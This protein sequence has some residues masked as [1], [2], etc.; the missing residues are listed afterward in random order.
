MK[1]VLLL[2][3]DTRAL[4]GLVRFFH[5][6]KVEVTVGDCG[7]RSIVTATRLAR[8]AYIPTEMAD[9][10]SYLPD[11]LERACREYA[12]DTILP[13]TDQAYWRLANTQLSGGIAELVIGYDNETYRALSDKGVVHRIAVQHFDAP[14]LVETIEPDTRYVIKDRA[15]FG[16][17]R[18]GTRGGVNLLFGCE[19]NGETAHKLVFEYLPGGCGAGIG[20]VAKDGRVLAMSA[21]RR[22]LEKKF[23]G[24][25]VREHIDIPPGMWERVERFT[26]AAGLSGLNMIEFKIIDGR[27]HFIELNPRPWG[28][29]PLYLSQPDFAHSLAELFELEPGPLRRRDRIQVNLVKTV[30]N[31]P[32]ALL[33]LLPK[34]P[35]LAFD[36]IGPEENLPLRLAGQKLCG[37]L[38]FRCHQLTSLFGVRGA[39][40]GRGAPVF[41]CFGNINRSALAEAI[42]LS[43]GRSATSCGTIERFG[44]V[45]SEMLSAYLDDCGME[46]SGRSRPFDPEAENLVIFDRKIYED[47]VFRLGVDR[48][49]IALF[50][51]TQVPDPHGGNAAAH[52]RVFDRIRARFEEWRADA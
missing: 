7:I 18:L 32:T 15:S 16:Q 38:S 24:S 25:A 34:L 8:Y 49:R 44:R 35:R 48:N 50:A 52:R 10:E 14:S 39:T 37:W 12:I 11:Y 3:G 30:R 22:L 23:A 51:P 27:W 28:S 13:V 4:Y 17:D 5:A 2:G 26:A 20:L 33:R 1:R 43:A 31:Q 41:V 40:G 29:L 19:L 47:L 21:H 36:E 42:S 46:L 6:A 45:R 9:L